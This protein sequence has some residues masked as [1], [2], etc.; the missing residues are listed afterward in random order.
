MSQ[1]VDNLVH[2]AVRRNEVIH[3]KRVRIANDRHKKLRR[4]DCMIYPQRDECKDDALAK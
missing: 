2:R 3:K 1:V 4:Y